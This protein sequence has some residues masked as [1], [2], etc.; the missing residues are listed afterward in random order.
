MRKIEVF[1]T[2]QKIFLFLSLGLNVSGLLFGLIA[3]GEILTH[4]FYTMMVLFP[5][6]GLIYVL[7]VTVRPTR[8]TFSLLLIVLFLA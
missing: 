1:N 4:I 6:T 3:E 5:S 8:L 2:W 7:G